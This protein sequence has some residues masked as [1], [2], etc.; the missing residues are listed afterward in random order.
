MCHHKELTRRFPDEDQ[1]G[2]T[3]YVIMRSLQMKFM[4]LPKARV[5]IGQELP[6]SAARLDRP[7]AP[8]DA[9]EAVTGYLGFSCHDVNPVVSINNPADLYSWTQIP[10]ELLIIGGAVFAFVHAIRRL[11]DGD[12]TN[13]ALCL[14][15][16]VYL[17]IT[18][19]PLKLVLLEGDAGEATRIIGGL[20][21]ESQPT[22]SPVPFSYSLIGG[23][24][25]RIVDPDHAGE[26]LPLFFAFSGLR[27]QL[28]LLNSAEAWTTC[29]VIIL[30][31]CVGKFGGSAVA[32]RSS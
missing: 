18:E 31:A 5:K 24:A 20:S 19:P 23:V 12:A 14:G 1:K 21:F 30:L 3:Y 16:L 10:L 9:A 27:T 15:S 7:V 29:G 2:I 17:A 32:A 22:W 13:L 26:L 28:G 4:R 25:G 6:E 11:R 8:D